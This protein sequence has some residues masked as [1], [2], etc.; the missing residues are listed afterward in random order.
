MTPRPFKL[1][2]ASGSS[3]RDQVG[4]LDMTNTIGG[5]CFWLSQQDGGVSSSAH[6]SPVPAGPATPFQVISSP[7]SRYVGCE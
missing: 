2:E 1:P 6:I 4:M 7:A 5:T 3:L